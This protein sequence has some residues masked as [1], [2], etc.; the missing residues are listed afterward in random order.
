MGIIKVR[1]LVLLPGRMCNERLWS[2]QLPRLVQQFN[3][4]HSRM[5]IACVNLQHPSCG[6]LGGMMDM[7]DRVVVDKEPQGE[8]G[9]DLKGT[10]GVKGIKGYRDSLGNSFFGGVQEGGGADC[11]SSGVGGGEDGVVALCGF[12]MGGFVAQNYVIRYPGRIGKLGLIGIS[13]RG[14]SEMQREKFHRAVAGLTSLRKSSKLKEFDPMG[15]DTLKQF[16]HFEGRSKQELEEISDSVRVMATEAGLEV[17]LRQTK[18]TAVRPNLLK[19]LGE[20]V[21]YP[22]LVI[23]GRNDKIVEPD[24][25]FEL[26]KAIPNSQFT[27]LDRCGHMSP[28]ERPAEVFKLMANWLK[29]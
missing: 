1:R 29:L 7:V 12:S 10:G 23:G 28:I 13:G 11:A 22:T 16:V 19:D 2:Y 6:S 26:A 8:R 27:L 9:G 24:E 3:S 17:F 21:T 25:V 5:Q 15:E 14:H 18:A 20:R 4:R